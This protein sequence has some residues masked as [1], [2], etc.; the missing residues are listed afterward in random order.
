VRSTGFRLVRLKTSSS[1]LEDYSQA[2]EGLHLLRRRIFRLSSKD[3][4]H[5]D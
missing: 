2:F 4:I 5:H 3:R 1:V